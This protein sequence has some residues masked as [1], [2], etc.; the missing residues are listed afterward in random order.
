MSM[1]RQYIVLRD[2]SGHSAQG[3]VKLFF[4]HQS[5]N[6]S[7]SVT[8]MPRGA[9]QL[10]IWDGTQLEAWPMHAVGL[11]Q[12]LQVKHPLQN[13]RIEAAV[14]EQGGRMVALGES[15]DP[16]ADWVAM[17]ARIQGPART[18]TAPQAPRE[19]PPAATPATAP[20][21]PKTPAPEA[22]EKRTANESAQEHATPDKAPTLEKKEIQRESVAPRPQ[23][24]QADEK[25]KAAAP[26]RWQ[27]EAEDSATWRQAQGE[28]PCPPSQPMERTPWPAQ[29]EL[30]LIERLLQQ[31]RPWQSEQEESVPADEIARII[32]QEL[33]KNRS[34]EGAEP[35]LIGADLE[36]LTKQAAGAAKEPLSGERENAESPEAEEQTEEQNQ[37]NA[38]PAAQPVREAEKEKD[39][40]GAGD[41]TS[42]TELVPEREKEHR[43]EVTAE[44]ASEAEREKDSMSTGDDASQ[45]EPVPDVEAA[46]EEQAQ[47]PE[48][49]STLIREPEGEDDPAPV[50]GPMLGGEYAGQWCW[51]RVEAAGAQGYYL[52]GCVERGGVNVAT[53]VAV[54][55]AY[56]PQPPAYLQGFSIYRDGF[57]VLAQDCETGRT[58]AV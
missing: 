17:Q 29:S 34:A 43:Q 42:Q 15:D 35:I 31:A 44:P 18:K 21:T 10:Y 3:F 9:Y 26:W 12:R 33:E 47:T 53:A 45:A 56:A 23:Q 36:T 27:A 20:Q 7:A 55:G 22:M 39:S 46:P 54:P 11:E 58:L 6:I 40:A 8:R 24:K 50:R 52:L 1:W 37:E 38:A 49:Q 30:P 19:E 57:W 16:R 13:G 4:T 41:D 32:Q 5:C 51:K 2:R 28:V 25:A 14:V 48:G